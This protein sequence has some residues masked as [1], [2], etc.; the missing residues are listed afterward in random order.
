M[1]NPAHK[2]G[3]VLIPEGWAFAEYYDLDHLP[4]SCV[5]SCMAAMRFCITCR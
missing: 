2:H 3:L 4:S 5:S 1:D